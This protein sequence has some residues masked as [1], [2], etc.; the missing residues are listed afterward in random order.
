MGSNLCSGFDIAP[1]FGSSHV[2]QHIDAI[3]SLYSVGQETGTELL[4]E[5]PNVTQ[6]GTGSA[7]I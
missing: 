7:R 2:N 1:G 4:N 6:L 5:L 3:I